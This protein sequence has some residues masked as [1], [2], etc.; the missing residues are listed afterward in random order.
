MD[1]IQY[2][3]SWMLFNAMLAVLPVLFGYF[4]L[5]ARARSLKIVLGVLWLV[6]LPNTIYIY[7]D[8]MHL[9][10]QWPTVS[11]AEKPII[12]L[13]HIML[14]VVGIITF[15]LAYRPLEI[16]LASVS[17]SEKQKI[18]AI[19]LFN[20]IIT[21]GI[22]LGR[23]ERVNSWEVISDPVNVI[24]S[25]VTVLTT[26]STLGLLVL[27]W[28]V[29]NCIYFLFRDPVLRLTKNSYRVISRKLYVK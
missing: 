7:T 28:I 22:V 18:R 4:L 25:S 2:N 10:H 6:F 14:Q 5:L 8:L 23:I 13:Q 15:I 20:L 12:V 24:L 26:F 3:N 17:K 21:F 11:L 27:L 19:L 1:T 16:W 29:T 9:I